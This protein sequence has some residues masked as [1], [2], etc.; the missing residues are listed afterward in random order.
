LSRA[1]LGARGMALVLAGILARPVTARAAEPVEPL[2]RAVEGAV[3]IADAPSNPA[4]VNL[5]RAPTRP[6]PT[7]P[8]SERVRVAIGLSTEALGT[9]SELQILDRLDHGLR[10]SIRPRADVRRL[11]A[12]AAEARTQC[13]DGQED[14]VM[15]VGYVPNR[16]EPVLLSRDCRL[17]RELGIRGMAAAADPALLGALWNEH[18]ELVR[19]GARERRALLRISP[20]TRGILIGVG[21]AIV[22]GVAI[23]LVL[24]STLRDDR[25]VVRVA[26]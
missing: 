11:R 21:A 20:K 6:R 4:T 23:G 16:D 19:A 25:V 2:P 13:R 22:V 10:A 24:A 3:G 14:L 7:T 8:S 15:L 9:A 26:P 5:S 17:D 18:G 1:G 12:G